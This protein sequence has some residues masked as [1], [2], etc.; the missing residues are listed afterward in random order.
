[1]G[2]EHN[3]NTLHYILMV[4]G[5]A[6]LHR[7]YRNVC[8]SNFLFINRNMPCSKK[9]KV[10]QW[11]WCES[12]S[13]YLTCDWQFAGSFLIMLWSTDWCI[14]TRLVIPSLST[15]QSSFSASLLTSEWVKKH[16]NESRRQSLQTSLLF[17]EVTGK[18]S[19]SI[20]ELWSLS[21]RL[22]RIEYEQN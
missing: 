17:T 11:Y 21:Y 12:L 2:E 22:G 6:L 7:K 18:K 4:R 13:A 20:F 9:L 8:K 16:K 15:T 14:L 1:M 3:K 5:N 10:P 19:L